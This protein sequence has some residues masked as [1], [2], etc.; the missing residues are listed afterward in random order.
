MAQWLSPPVALSK[1]LD[2]LATGVPIHTTFIYN[3]HAYTQK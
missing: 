1:D 3:V 2:L